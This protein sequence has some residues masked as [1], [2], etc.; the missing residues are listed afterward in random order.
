MSRAAAQPPAAP[1]MSGPA[2]RGSGMLVVKLT[3]PPARDYTADFSR[4]NA[5]GET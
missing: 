2:I 1:L 3:W 5:G 4:N